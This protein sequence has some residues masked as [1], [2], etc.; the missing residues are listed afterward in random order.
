MQLGGAGLSR[1]PPLPSLR[2]L[3]LLETDVNDSD[4]QC[5]R[6]LPNLQTL[7]LMRTG[8]TDVGLANLKEASKLETLY[9]HLLQP[10]P[11]ERA[12]KVTDE[13]IRDLQKALPKLKIQ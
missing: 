6:R 2:E 12:L 4:L 3:R 1:L 5:V 7:D 11:G 13:A 10:P 8:V 9:L